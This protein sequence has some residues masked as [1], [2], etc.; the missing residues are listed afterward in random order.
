[1]NPALIYRDM[2]DYYVRCAAR[3]ADQVYDAM[4]LRD[5]L[6][7]EIAELETAYTT[8]AGHAARLDQQARESTDDPSV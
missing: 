7:R 8:A 2:S 1:M 6:T 4:E 3:I 5:R